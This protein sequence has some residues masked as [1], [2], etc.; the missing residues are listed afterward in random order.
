MPNNARVDFGVYIKR[1]FLTI[2]LKKVFQQKL[3]T[4]LIVNK[5]SS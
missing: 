5:I 3:N 2:I 1:N 4:F